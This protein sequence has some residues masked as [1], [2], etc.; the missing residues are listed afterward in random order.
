VARRRT[1]NR[2][3]LTRRLRR[4]TIKDTARPATGC[5]RS[6]WLN[7]YAAWV[8]LGACLAVSTAATLYLKANVERDE[9]RELALRCTDVQH[10]IENRL[11]DH[12]RVLISGAALFD[13][14]ASVSRGEWS[15]YTGRQGIARQLPGVQGMGYAQLIPRADLERHIREIRD[16][17]FRSQIAC[18]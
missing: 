5:G 1:I 4:R 10:A 15:A 16:E 12:A 13:A 2:L 3:R 9:E 11:Q 18:H 8:V 6:A 14:S 17:G 7:R